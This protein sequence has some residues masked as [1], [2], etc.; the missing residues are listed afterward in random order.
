[1]KLYCKIA[2]IAGGV[3]LVPGILVIILL[4]RPP[5]LV[6]T[7]L[8]CV[9]L[10]GAGRIRLEGI[11]SSVTLF[12]RVKTIAIA[13]DAGEDIF[14]AAVTSASPQP[15]CVLFPLRFARIARQYREQKPEIPVVLLEGRYPSVGTNPASF[16]I[17]NNSIADYFVYTTDITADFYRAGL[18]AVI[19]DGEKNG[20]AAIFLESHIQRQGREAFSRALKSQEKTMETNY[21]TSFS[22][23]G[24]FTDFSCVIIAGNGAEYLEGDFDIPVIV[25]SWINPSIIPIGVILVFDDS[26][27]IQAVPAVRMVAAGVKT[28]QIPSKITLLPAGNIDKK[29]RQ[30]LKDSLIK[31][32]KSNKLTNDDL[33]KTG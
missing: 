19:L 24:K 2:A 16:A 32:N 15:F 20:R 5:V 6:V 28:G 10:Y 14:L 31:L 9:S 30:R 12:R 11:R 4:T 25:F 29:T 8:S 27:W 22:Q 7:D 21:Y 23:F 26:P 17:N 3:I 1:M 18:A 33:T 13:D